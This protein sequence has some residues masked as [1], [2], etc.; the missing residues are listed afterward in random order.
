MRCNTGCALRL[1][2]GVISDEL[3]GRAS[4]D[5][6]DG[7]ASSDGGASALIFGVPAWKRRFRPAWMQIAMGACEHGRFRPASSGCR[8]CL[9]AVALHG[10]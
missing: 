8:N 4:S 2:H 3:D 1:P 10:A 7:R 9:P 6:L 5:G